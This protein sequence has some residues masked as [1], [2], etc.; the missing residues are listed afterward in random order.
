MSQLSQRVYAHW[1]SWRY[2]IGRNKYQHPELLRA[3]YQ[4]DLPELAQSWL[5]APYLALDFE[6]TGL[7]PRDDQILSMGW[8]AAQGGEITLGQHQHLLVA[9]QQPLAESSVVIHEITDD[10]A[11]CG[12]P[13]QQA[14][15]QLIH[16]LKGR[17]LIAHNAR[18]ELAFLQRAVTKHTQGRL[19]LPVID[20]MQLAKRRLDR[21]HKPQERGALRLD[22]LRQRY[23]LPRY[24]AHHA[25][26]DA[27]ATAELFSAIAQH[28]SPKRPQTLQELL[29][30]Y[31]WQ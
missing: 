3:Y 26:V 2:Q 21:E 8:V 25:L 6:T 18:F 17:V 15:E 31:W 24:K 30:P 27:L 12:L 4:Q 14:L 9:P 10:Q 29:Y 7:N 22:A 16:A 11:A 1:L 5:T 19:V 20:T 23:G 13:M 28:H